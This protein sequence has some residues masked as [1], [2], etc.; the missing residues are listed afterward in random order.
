MITRSVVSLVKRHPLLAG[1]TLMFAL[2]WPIDLARA[3]H[4]QGWITFQ[5]PEALAIFVGYGFVVASITAT[6]IIGGRAEVVA[7]L[8]RFLIWRVGWT[9]YAIA[10]FLPLALTLA[11]IAIYSLPSGSAPDFSEPF[12]RQLFGSGVNLVY[13]V[14]PFL[15]F[16]AIA[17][18]EEIG[19]RGY[20][21]PRLQGRYKAVIASL[22]VGL[23]WGLWHLP[24]FLVAG[25]ET[26]I[27]IYLIDIM[28]RAIL[29]TWIFNNT[30]GSLL[31]VT[32]FHA[33]G[34]TAGVFL[35]IQ[36]AVV[37]IALMNWLAAF[38]VIAFAGWDLS[39]RQKTFKKSYPVLPG[40][41]R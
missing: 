37:P 36:A 21:L 10:L 11:G 40:D 39:D 14:I 16:D 12:A 4:S 2:T 33:A 7:L 34:N 41:S 31:L 13:L 17:N 9:W 29:Y 24:K 27:S 8:R 15:L 6:W 30:R 3:A 26:V 22:I 18:G 5:I 25:N 38:S 32:L 35:P 19:W 23:I 20:L 1:L 28:A